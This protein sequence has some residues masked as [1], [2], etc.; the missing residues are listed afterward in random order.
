[1]KQLPMRVPGCPKGVSAETIV[2]VVFGKG[3]PR[4][5][6]MLAEHLPKCGKCRQVAIAARAFQ[7]DMLRVARQ[8]V[9][10]LLSYL[11]WA[12]RT[13]P[14]RSSKRRRKK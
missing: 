12:K 6:E 8:S 2:A 14:S 7:A 13:P 10:S 5:V 9:L 4:D 3:S 11:D 1:M